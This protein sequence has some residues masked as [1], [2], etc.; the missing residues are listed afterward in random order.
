M[1]LMAIRIRARTN[2]ATDQPATAVFVTATYHHFYRI[3]VQLRDHL[4]P[5]PL[6][7]VRARAK[8]KINVVLRLSFLFNFVPFIPIIKLLRFLIIFD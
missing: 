2:L 1:A 7:Q 6:R 4:K 8:R 5:T 3:R